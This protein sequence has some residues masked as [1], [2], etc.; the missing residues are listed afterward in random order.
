MAI[1]IAEEPSGMRAKP[2]SIR[3]ASSQG[4]GMSNAIAAEA[5]E[6][7][8]RAA[9]PVRRAAK[10]RSADLTQALRLEAAASALEHIDADFHR[11]ENDR[12]RLLAC[13]LRDMGADRPLAEELG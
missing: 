2:S 1:T 7:V 11:H 12:L 4:V 10:A 8:R 13:E 6:I 9:A 5:Q 3:I